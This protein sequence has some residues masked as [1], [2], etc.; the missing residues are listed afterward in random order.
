LFFD[1]KLKE[2]VF[3]DLR[4]SEAF[5][6][7]ADRARYEKMIWHSEGATV[8]VFFSAE[9]PQ[10]INTLGKMPQDVHPTPPKILKTKTLEG[11]SN[12]ECQRFSRRSGTAKG[13]LFTLD[14]NHSLAFTP[15]SKLK[16]LM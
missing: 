15:S 8:G 5:M 2:G 12:V 16:V 14:C 10:D 3:L 7:F 4:H 11:S 13:L 9:G 6:F 1:N